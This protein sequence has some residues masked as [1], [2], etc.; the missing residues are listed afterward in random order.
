MKMK[1]GLFATAFAALIGC[2]YFPALPA[3][4]EFEVASIK[5]TRSPLG[6]N[7]GCH[8]RDARFAPTDAEA[9]VPLGRCVIT[10]GRLTHIM[11]IAYK[12]DVN[13]I[14]GRPDWDG[15][16]RFDLEAKAEH[17]S[18]TQ[19]ELLQMLRNLLADRF[20]LKVSSET[21]E[22]SGYALVVA[23]NGPKFKEAQHDEEVHLVVRGSS[24][25]KKD[26]AD[27]QKLPL[28]TVTGRNVSLHSLLDILWR[29][30][31]APVADRTG[32]T[33]SYDFTLNWEP[34]EDLSGPLQQQLGLKLEA[35]KVPVEYMKIVS[36]ER[37]MEN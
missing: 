22:E 27:G 34:G 6:V 8:G 14:E 19:D 24:I 12:F 35:Q 29:A 21:K 5:P 26:A 16:S 17:E 31:G 36:A 28:N 3:A 1:A 9:G 10:A 23:K 15:P 33:G 11:A 2:G 32:L 37:P 18:A 13:R 30:A 25:N 20:K 4:P 7:G